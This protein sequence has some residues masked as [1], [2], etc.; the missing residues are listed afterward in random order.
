VWR[1]CCAPAAPLVTFAADDDTS[2][3]AA[4]SLQLH[5]EANLMREAIMDHQ[6]SSV[7]I[8]GHQWS[9]VVIRGHQWIASCI[10]RRTLASTAERA[11]AAARA[12][13]AARHDATRALS[14]SINA[15]SASRLL[16]AA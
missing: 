7:V 6:W 11:A 15:K 9:S 16:R 2:S 1:A 8:S 3:T 13:T 14:L 5:Q 4:A 12:S 10:K